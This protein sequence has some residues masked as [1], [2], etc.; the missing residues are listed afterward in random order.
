[1]ESGKR[2]RK[3]TGEKAKPA[4]LKTHKGCGTPESLGHPPPVSLAIANP[5]ID[6]EPLMAEEEKSISEAREWLKHNP[7]IPHE[8]VL[9]ELGIT[10]NGSRISRIKTR[11]L[12]NPQ[13][14]RHPRVSSPPAHPKMHM[15]GLYHLA[16][17]LG[18]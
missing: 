8:Q 6:D 18:K 1:M 3:A 2:G 4:P 11:T 10:R 7:G 13:G 17:C 9:A 15:A 12:V 14:M 16:N 5:P